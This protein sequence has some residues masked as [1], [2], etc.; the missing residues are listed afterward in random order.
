MIS[1]VPH[2][3]INVEGLGITWCRQAHTRGFVTL[4]LED[5]ID[6]LRD[7]WVVSCIMSGIVGDGNVL[8]DDGGIHHHF[9]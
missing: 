9:H 2:P 7:G 1:D 8:R 6:R 3:G 5:A 4:T